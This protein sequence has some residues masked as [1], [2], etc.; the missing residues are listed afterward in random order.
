MEEVGDANDTNQHQVGEGHE[1]LG[2]EGLGTDRPWDPRRRTPSPT[3]TP[4]LAP[5]YAADLIKC[6]TKDWS[7]NWQFD[8]GCCTIS[9]QNANCID[10]YVVQWTKDCCAGGS[11]AS[12]SASASTGANMF[13]SELAQGSA[14]GSFEACAGARR[15]ECRVPVGGKASPNHRRRFNYDW[16][17]PTNNTCVTGSCCAGG[18]SCNVCEEHN[19]IP[20]LN[21]AQCGAREGYVCSAQF[22]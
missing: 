6:L 14:E 3:A 18:S 22:R 12:G 16:C 21:G 2:R 8:E 5:T 17:P 11:Q 19:V 15:F 7:F 1:G 4:T 9:T 13:G 20:N 10:G